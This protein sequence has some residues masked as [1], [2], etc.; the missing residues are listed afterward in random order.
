MSGVFEEL[1]FKTLGKRILGEEIQVSN[2]AKPQAAES[3]QM[4]LFGNNVKAENKKQ[5]NY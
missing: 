1:E 3:A 4:D 2:Y 5:G